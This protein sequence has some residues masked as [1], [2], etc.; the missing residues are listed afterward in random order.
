MYLQRLKKLKDL[1][2]GPRYMLVTLCGYCNDQGD[3]WPSQKELAEATG[4]SLRTVNSHLKELCQKGYIES[5]KR[6]N[7]KGDLDSCLYTV[8][9]DLLP[10]RA[11]KPSKVVHIK[12]KRK[13]QTTAEKLTD[14]SWA[15]DQMEVSF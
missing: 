5:Q 14:T 1:K 6:F 9:I 11:K 15:D 4:F 3:C 12:P 13:Q 7:S 10:A 2:A 8:K